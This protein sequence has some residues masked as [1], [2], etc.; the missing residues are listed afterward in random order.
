MRTSLWEMLAPSCRLRFSLDDIMPFKAKISKIKA[1]FKRLPRVL[2]GHAF[3]F[4]LGL[5]LLGFLSSAFLFYKYYILVQKKEVP[6]PPEPVHLEQEIVEQ[7][8]QIWQIRKQDFD[9]A[10]IKEYLDPFQEVRGAVGQPEPPAETVKPEQAQPAAEEPEHNITA[11]LKARTL[12]EFYQ[13]QGRSLPSADERAKIWQEKGLGTKQ[14]YL[15]FD[16]Q[17]WKLLE[18][19]KQELRE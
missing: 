7:V 2:I 8:L 12:T 15:G 14:E 4:F 1:L 10:G 6:S 18:V 16:F 3:L 5:L 11:L 19:L 13:L 9:R 17:N